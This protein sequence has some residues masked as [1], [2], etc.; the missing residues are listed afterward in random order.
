[1]ISNISLM[2]LAL[3]IFTL[4]TSLAYADKA[5]KK[6]AE[7]LQMEAETLQDLYRREPNAKKNV[8]NAA[9]FA[10]FVILE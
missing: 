4:L 7:I 1:M 2:L 10:V 5:E 6:K 9:G 3:F 8:Q